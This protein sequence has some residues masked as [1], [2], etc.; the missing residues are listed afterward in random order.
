MRLCKFQIKNYKNLE[1]IDFTWDDIIILI[2]EN[3]TGKSSVLEALDWFLSGKQISDTL[4]YRNEKTDEGNA[5]ELIGTFDNLSMPDLQKKAIQGRTYQSKWILRKKY[6][7]DPK[8]NKA[9][10][11]YFS[12]GEIDDFSD[13][14]EKG[15]KKSD[16][17]ENYHDLIDKAKEKLDKTSITKDVQNELKNLVKQEKPHLVTSKTDWIP[18]PG[19]GEG[20]KSNANSIIPK[21][22]LVP[23][24]YDATVEG[25]S[26]ERQSMTTYGEIL[27]LLIEKKLANREEVKKLKTTIN[28]VKALFQ[29]D[30]E[31][32]EWK[33]AKEVI[34]FQNDLSALLSKVIK[35]KAF[36]EPGDIS[37][38]DIVLPNT[39]LLID[40][41][42]KTKIAGQGHG[43]QR[44]LI[45]SLLQML[46]D[47]ETVPVA[48]EVN[49]EGASEEETFKRPVVF[50]IEEPELYMHPQIE[51]KMRDT[52]YDL[53]ESDNYQVICSTHS[54][55]FIDMAEKHTAIVRLEI[56]GTRKITPKQVT[57][58]IFT[59]EN[60]IDDK[61]RLRMITNFDP[62]VNE[63]FFA[64]RVVLVEGDT[65]IAV[66]QRSAELMG[67]FDENPHV[68][69]DTTFIN[70]HGKWTI[71]LFLEVLNHFGVEYIVFHDEDQNKGGNVLQANEAIGELVQSPNERR[72][73]S[74]NDLESVLGYDATT[75]DKPITALKKTEELAASDSIPSEFQ[76]HVKV[77]W[78]VQ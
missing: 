37:I 69:R 50:A 30:P 78:G 7:I 19:G 61:K 36:L 55:V 14:P 41:G 73:F 51:R 22:I 25:K 31:N 66:F 74:P 43:L 47:Y 75:K 72:M 67:L 42:F 2:G 8:E 49:T 68:K 52:L 11:Q 23:A 28:Q 38:S 20:W 77:A 9:K 39:T 58:E 54:P 44:T 21:Y 65:E 4:L 3:N 45:M 71:I 56:D 57:D 6:W 46:V 16:W 12:Y 63:L 34:D 32:P 53:S 40:D 24:V 1:N 5:I 26:K 27:S 70:C 59:G 33:Q 64:K 48:Q 10:S 18:D 76:E 60:A 15:K 17:P 29:P 13:W 35:S 62:A